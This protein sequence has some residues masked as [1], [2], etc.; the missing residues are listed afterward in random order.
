MSSH[1]A[2]EYTYKLAR[3]SRLRMSCSLSSEGGVVVS[4]GS[5]H[6]LSKY[7]HAGMAL[8][9]GLPTGVIVKFK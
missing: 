8:E 3:Q 7:I 5:D 1:L 9:C 4:L 6:K 2:G